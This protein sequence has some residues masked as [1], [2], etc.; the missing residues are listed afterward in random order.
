MAVVR[1]SLDLPDVEVQDLLRFTGAAS[2]QDAI[3]AAVVEFNR[4]RRIAAL[5]GHAGQG[6][7]M[8]TPESLQ[9]SRRDRGSN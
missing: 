9:A 3:V 6:E 5:A 7:L 2:I 8:A 4:R 1:V